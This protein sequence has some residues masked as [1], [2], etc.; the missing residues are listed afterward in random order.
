[1][2]KGEREM[3]IER[4]RIASHLQN[5]VVDLGMEGLFMNISL[6]R[7]PVSLDRECAEVR[8]QVPSRNRRTNTRPKKNAIEE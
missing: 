7:M 5:D 6:Y 2:V 3:M 4:K 8:A 1:M